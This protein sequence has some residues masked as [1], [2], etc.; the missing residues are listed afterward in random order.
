MRLQPDGSIDATFNPNQAV[1][2]LEIFDIRAMALDGEGKLVIGGSQVGRINPDGSRD[3]SFDP[4]G[5]SYIG[6][7]NSIALQTDGKI[8]LGGEGRDAGPQYPLPVPSV[9]RLLHDNGSGTTFEF[10]VVNTA[11]SEA[12][13]GVILTVERSGDIAGAST[14]EYATRDGTAQ[15]GVDYAASKGRISF[16]P[17][18][19]SKNISIPFIDDGL[20]ESDEFFEVTFLSN[21]T[22]GGTLGVPNA[23]RVT[24]L[25]DDRVGSVEFTFPAI[26][27]DQGSLIHYVESAPDRSVLF[28]DY[29]SL[30]RYRADGSRD[31]NFSVPNVSAFARTPNGQIV[32][33]GQFANMHDVQRQGIARLNPDGTLDASFDPG[34]GIDPLSFEDSGSDAFEP[35]PWAFG[36]SVV[37]LCSQP[38]G[39]ILVGGSFDRVGG[40]A[41]RG[42]ARLHSD[43][44]LDMSFQPRLDGIRNFDHLVWLILLQPDGKFLINGSFEKVDGISRDGLARL[45]Q[46]GSLD[47]E[48]QPQVEFYPC[49]LL[50]LQADGKSLIYHQEE[51]GSL[52]DG[53]NEIVRLNS[54]GTKDASFKCLI[55]LENCCDIMPGVSSAAI[56]NDGKIVIVGYFSQVNGIDRHGVA[57]LNP[58]GSIDPKF[59]P[60]ATGYN[61]FNSLALQADGQI[62]I[63]AGLLI[64][65]NGGNSF[66]Q[67]GTASDFAS[68]RATN[69]LVTVRR[70][71]DKSSTARVDYFTRDL[72]G[73]AGID[74]ASQTGTIQFAAFE[75]TKTI[76]VPII[77]NS[78]I[79]QDDRIFGLLLTNASSGTILR[80]P[81][82]EQITILDDDRPGSL[83]PGVAIPPRLSNSEES[84]HVVTRQPDATTF[85]LVY[86]AATGSPEK[87]LRLSRDGN[88]IRELNA[89]GDVRAVVTQ[90]DGGVVIGRFF[91]SLIGDTRDHLLSRLNPDGSIDETYNPQITIANGVSALALQPDGKLLVGGY[92]SAPN[93][94]ALVRFNPDGS[95]DTAF[96]PLLSYT[97]S[98]VGPGVWSIVVQPDRKI[99]ISGTFT[100]VNG[101]SRNSLAWLNPDGSLDLDFDLGA[102]AV[103][104]T[105]LP[106]GKTLMAGPFK[107]TDGM[108]RIGIVRLMPDGS[109]DGSF[110]PVLGFNP[111][112][113]LIDASYW[114]T[115]V[116][117]DGRFLMSYSEIG[118]GFAH[119]GVARVNQDG[120]ID[121]G[122]IL[123]PGVSGI[124]GLA[125]NGG[126]FAF[127][128]EQTP[129]GYAAQRIVA[130]TGDQN[131]IRL[132]SH[133]PV[134][135]QSFS[136]SVTTQPGNTYIIE[137]TPNLL[138]WTP[139]ST[140]SASAFTTDFSDASISGISN[141]F[142]RARLRT[143]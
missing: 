55:T 67:V 28:L 29:S 61:S 119:Y 60:S 123:A 74:Y 37:A 126:L 70:A 101:V 104:L 6:W 38:D 128:V 121:P 23:T 85:L 115:F 3:K 24:I 78:R 63:A 21:P 88:V 89:R 134:I 114:V 71:G 32:V 80:A 82:E 113:S 43:G 34:L 102:G 95:L 137:H 7:V 20:A 68:E 15:S 41:R 72:T 59:E 45:K 14:V 107:A 39:D 79:G 87:L 26:W 84:L 46:D 12:R 1:E 106:D 35:A 75:T 49:K 8:V 103:Q 57:R 51:G 58:D 132:K 44:S 108:V 9:A 124:V 16:G 76:Q 120:S 62:L 19:T 131:Y 83:D 53:T 136:L 141:R 77:N 31:F 94:V 47:L 10:A 42:L 33:A 138:D 86:R 18:E 98:A 13:G 65:L 64:R 91:N 73:T 69:V 139:L 66:L 97:N 105:A 54:D 17:S 11:A 25:D 2:E 127:S 92:A 36:A 96:Q 117:P 48:F 112:R 99:L 30:R 111:Q 125:P 40:A 140:N 4:R 143:P 118:D 90:S 116:Y 93:G 81:Q 129:S 130:L 142:Y 110:R 100:S 22:N 122:F 133:P 50:A 109:F 52:I 135:E 56:Q 5:R 27:E